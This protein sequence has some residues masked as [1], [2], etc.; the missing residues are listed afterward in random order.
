MP[1]EE[2]QLCCRR[3]L[4]RWQ[5]AEIKK[6][7]EEEEERKQSRIMDEEENKK[8]VLVQNKKLWDVLVME[9]KTIEEATWSNWDAGILACKGQA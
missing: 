5:M 6:K 1:Q 2:A 9:E 3:E 4:K 7:V 8:M